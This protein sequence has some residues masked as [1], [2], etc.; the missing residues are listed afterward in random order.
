MKNLLTTFIAFFCL[1][2]GQN[3]FGQSKS[4]NELTVAVDKVSSDNEMKFECTKIVYN[5]K[6]Q[7]TKFLEN[8]SLKTD[9]VE[10]T[11]AD[12]VIYNRV[13]KKM[14]IYGCKDFT[15]DGKIVTQIKKHKK[16]VIEY[17]FGDDTA[18]IL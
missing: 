14:T 3:S 8:V 18:Y 9:K 17:T 11:S 7:E 5:D 12:K 6:S 1:T 4:T 16:N 10:F 2:F 15:I 13:T